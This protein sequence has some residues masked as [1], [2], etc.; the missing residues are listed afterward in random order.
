MDPVG[1]V[2]PHTCVRVDSADGVHGGVDSIDLGLLSGL[3]AATHLQ[4]DGQDRKIGRHTA[5]QT[6]MTE[7]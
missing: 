2:H 7:R 3:T 5:R 4:T 6:D 1:A